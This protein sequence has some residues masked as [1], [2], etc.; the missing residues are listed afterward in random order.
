MDDYTLIR[1]YRNF[2]A[3]LVHEARI[4]FSEVIAHAD[5]NVVLDL[6][7]SNN[8]DSS[9]IGAIAFLYKRLNCLGFTLELIGLNEQSFQLINL[10]QI[11]DT[12]Q[13]YPRVVSDIWKSTSP[14]CY[15]TA[16][17]NNKVDGI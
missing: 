1:C 10:L 13:C 17:K 9:G 5:R 16:N 3:H 8:M 15:K 7:M 6:S 2:D 14:L 4:V 12:I 11:S